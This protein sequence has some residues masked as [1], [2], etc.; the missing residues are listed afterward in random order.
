MAGD[1]ALVM[2]SLVLIMAIF[3]SEHVANGLTDEEDAT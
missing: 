3:L 2:T 1:K